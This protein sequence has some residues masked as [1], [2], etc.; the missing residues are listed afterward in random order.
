MGYY[1]LKENSKYF[2][3]DEIEIIREYKTQKDIL[4]YNG[5]Y[6]ENKKEKI[7][8][9]IVKKHDLD[10][11]AFGDSYLIDYDGVCAYSINDGDY[12]MGEGE[13]MGRESFED[14]TVTFEDIEE[15]YIDN[16]CRAV[17]A[18]VELPKNWHKLPIDFASGHYG[19]VDDPETILKK[20]RDKFEKHDFIFKID[21]AQPFEVGFNLCAKLR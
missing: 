3:T 4:I 9:A 14:Q 2:Q 1:G 10:F 6:P 17:P 8:D 20:Y 18:W 11:W 5:S 13:I 12:I 15:L 16:F 21:Y 7:L 19:T